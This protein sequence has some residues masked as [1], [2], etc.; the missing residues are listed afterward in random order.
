VDLVRRLPGAEVWVRDATARHRFEVLV[1]GQVAGFSAYRMEGDAVA[2][3]HTEVFA[4]YAGKGLGSR[5]ARD[6]LSQLRGRGVAVLPYC[7]FLRAYLGKHP[8]QQDLVPAGDLA[9]LGLEA[10]S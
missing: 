4:A 7:P 9:R 3:T 8:E 1:G 2:I 5:L 6:V 10:P